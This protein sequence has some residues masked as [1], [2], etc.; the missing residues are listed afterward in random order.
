MQLK[1]K[2]IRLI[3]LRP[4]LGKSQLLLSKQNLSS[5]NVFL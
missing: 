1:K 3:K 2:T 4:E 5:L